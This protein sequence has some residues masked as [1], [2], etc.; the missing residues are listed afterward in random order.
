MC[1]RTV[2]LHCAAIIWIYYFISHI[3]CCALSFSAAIGL[4]KS[5]LL[6]NLCVRV[7]VFVTEQQLMLW[8]DEQEV[9]IPH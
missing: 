6:F 1:C 3:Y 4:D 7:C 9:A 5:L 8:L 2:F